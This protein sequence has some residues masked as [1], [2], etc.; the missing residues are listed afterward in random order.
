MSAVEQPVSHRRRLA[1]T[2]A[3]AGYRI[4]PL[5]P[6]TKEPATPHGFKDATPDVEQVE[7]WWER[8]PDFNIGLACGMQDNGLYVAVI[9]VDAK[10][11]GVLAWKQLCRDNG[12]TWQRYMPIHKTPRQGFHIFGSVDPALGLNASNGFP[13]GIDTRGAGGYVVL[14]DSVFIDTETGEIGSYTATE[15]NLWSTEPGAF[16]EWVIAMWVAGPTREVFERHPSSQPFDGDTPVTWMKANINWFKEIQDDKFTLEADYGGEVRWTREGKSKGN[17][18]SLHTDGHGCVVVWSDN[19]PDWMT[20]HTAGQ[21]TRSGQWSMNGFQYICA[22]DH[23]GDI[24]AAMSAIRLERMPPP[25][26]RVTGSTAEDESDS[27]PIDSMCL[28]DW[29]WSERSWLTQLR[30]SAWSVGSVPESILAAALARIAVM[31][32]PKWMIP[33]IIHRQATLDLITVLVGHTGSG[34]SG[35]MGRAAD[36]LPCAFEDRRFDLGIGSGEGM[37]ESYYGMVTRENDEGKKVKERAKAFNGIHFV[38]D[39]GAIFTTLAGRG[40][41]SGVDRILT[42]WSG[43]NLSTPNAKAETFR[44][45][46]RGTYRFAMTMAIQIEL[47]D[48]LWANNNTAQGF[49]GRLTMFSGLSRTVPE[50]ENWPADPGPIKI[51]LPMDHGPHTLGYPAWFISEIRKADHVR[52]TLTKDPDPL[53]AH[54]NLQRCKLAGIFALIEGRFDVD[55][56]DIALASAVVDTS[57]TVRAWLMAQARSSSER[58]FM[59]TAERKGMANAL[60]SEAAD[61]QILGKT[62]DV[63][64][65]KLKERDMSRGDLRRYIT[66]SK[67]EYLDAALAMLEG[68][69]KVE[70]GSGQ[71]WRWI[72]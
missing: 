39:E 41:W 19:C 11:G 16:P 8:N 70:G 36:I 29:F 35:P 23:G 25:P 1:V 31:T 10:H 5:L 20:A 17:S 6:N 56:G 53:S 71:K 54:R 44:H 14:P 72:G 57:D 46:E 67:R 21:W 18:L 13:K 48:G 61:K 22:R 15:N 51:N 49:T 26:A 4:F 42:A 50:E 30:Q 69:A 32:S 58:S 3:Q 38:V 64:S 60:E 37:I 47:A 12:G 52:K 34:K 63:V 27:S 68:M 59:D 24:G 7:A 28:P 33:A 43:G 9:D 2:A 55:D 45:I 66:G 65:A 62:V 40:G